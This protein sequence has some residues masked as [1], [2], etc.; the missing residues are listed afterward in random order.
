[1]NKKNLTIIILF[2][3]LIVFFGFLKSRPSFPAGQVHSVVLTEERFS[4]SDLT[5]KRGDTVVFTATTGRDF[6]PA[7]DLHPTHGIYPEFDPRE[8]IPAGQNWSFIFKKAGEW[9]YHD[10]L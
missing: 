6:W 2:I 5:V 10:H 4:P 3:S 7:S 1:M 9:K 8:P